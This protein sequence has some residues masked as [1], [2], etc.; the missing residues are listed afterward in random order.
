MA[1]HCVKEAD[2]YLKYSATGYKLFFSSHVVIN[3]CYMW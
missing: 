2:D 3:G 1:N